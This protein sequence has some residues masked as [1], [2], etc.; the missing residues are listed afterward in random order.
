M[1]GFDQGPETVKIT[2][3]AARLHKIADDIEA[4]AAKN[5]DHDFPDEMVPRLVVNLFTDD[6]AMTML[7][8]ARGR[9]DGPMAGNSTEDFREL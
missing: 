8:R 5:G 9:K 1:P 2:V 4:L 3:I 7:D 6:K